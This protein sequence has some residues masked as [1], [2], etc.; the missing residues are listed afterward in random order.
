MSGR[1]VRFRGD[2]RHIIPNS[3]GASGEPPSTP[4]DTLP[5]TDNQPPSSGPQSPGSSA[6][7]HTWSGYNSSDSR[8]LQGLSFSGQSS[9]PP[10]SW[11]SGEEN[12]SSQESVGVAEHHVPLLVVLRDSGRSH[13]LISVPLTIALEEFERR[14]FRTFQQWIV[15]N[16]SNIATRINASDEIRRMEVVWTGSGVQ[17][18]PTATVLTAANLR[19]LLF[20]LKHRGGRDAIEVVLRRE[21]IR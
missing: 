4:V 13:I 2:A 17:R 18:F 14:I 3:P 11:P 1:N 16:H 21:L 5:E 8:L 6:W 20:F 15:D 9:D 7:P 19:A 12:P 10:S